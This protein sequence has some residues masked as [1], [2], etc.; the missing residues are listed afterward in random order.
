MRAREQS[1]IPVR[2]MGQIRSIDRIG[3]PAID[4]WAEG[5]VGHSEP[6]A[7]NVAAPLQ[8][9]IE[10]LP[11][12]SHRADKRSKALMVALSWFRSDE[13]KQY[14]AH[15]RPERRALPG[16]PAVCIG[17]FKEPDQSD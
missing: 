17:I 2:K 9:A 13:A 4:V 6:I 5:D 15:W 8:A 7:H 11:V 12:L 3:K 1:L 10:Y 16:N 14:L